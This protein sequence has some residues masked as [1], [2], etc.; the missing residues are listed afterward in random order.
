MSKKEGDAAEIPKSVTSLWENWQQPNGAGPCAYCPRHWSRR[1][2]ISQEH[3][4]TPDNRGRGPW[5]AEGDFDADVVILAMEPGTKDTD[6]GENLNNDLERSFE[7]ATDDIRGVAQGTGSIERIKPLVN[8]LHEHN[9]PAY[10]TNTAKCNAIS[11]SEDHSKNVESSDTKDEVHALCCGFDDRSTR[12][13]LY[14][15][16]EAIDPSVVIT[17]G[18]DALVNLLKTYGVTDPKPFN[19][20]IIA[21]LLA[22]S[23]E[24]ALKQIRGYSVPFDVVSTYHPSYMTDGIPGKLKDEWEAKHGNNQNDW[25]RFQVCYAQFAHDFYQWYSQM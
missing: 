9:V 6:S 4:Q 10:Y 20:G 11:E 15:E 1:N 17:L 16:L 13:Y 14:E 25:N 18:D 24:S 12:T 21:D 8:L 5:Y 3:K 23:H 7:Q 2:D 22:S 19:E